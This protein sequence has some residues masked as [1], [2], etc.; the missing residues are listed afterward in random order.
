MVTLD[1]GRDKECKPIPGSLLCPMQP[2]FGVS[3]LPV[4]NTHVRRLYV[5]TS[6]LKLT[7]ALTRSKG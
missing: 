1:V 6:R 4:S 3:A 5:R 7:N 2:L